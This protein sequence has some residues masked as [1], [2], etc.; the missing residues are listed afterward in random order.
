MGEGRYV[1]VGVGVGWCRWLLVA[2]LIYLK[3][4][5]PVYPP[6]QRT[7][8][9]KHKQTGSVSSHLSPLLLLGD[10]YNSVVEHL[11]EDQKVTSSNSPMMS[12]WMKVSSN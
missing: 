12:L 8:A 4:L 9:L 10:K 6:Q 5:H 7:C 11:T 1:C 3:V 2:V